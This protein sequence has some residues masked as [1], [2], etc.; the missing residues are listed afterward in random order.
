[1]KATVERFGIRKETNRT[2]LFDKEQPKK[3]I[4]SYGSVRHNVHSKELAE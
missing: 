2:F 1:M 3:S 4:F